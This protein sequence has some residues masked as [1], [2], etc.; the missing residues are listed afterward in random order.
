MTFKLTK[1]SYLSQNKR[2]K[3]LVYIVYELDYQQRIS[4]VLEN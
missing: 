1:M 3:K 2:Q 4:F